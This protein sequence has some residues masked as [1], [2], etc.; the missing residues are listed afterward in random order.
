MLAREQYL[1]GLEHKP[2]EPVL[3]HNLGVSYAME[4]DYEHALNCF[5][6]AVSGHLGDSG[7]TT[8]LRLSCFASAGRRMR[9]NVPGN[10]QGLRGLQPHGRTL[11]CS[12]R[13]AHAIRC[14][15]RALELC[16]V[17]YKEAEDR[18]KRRCVWRRVIPMRNRSQRQRKV[19]KRAVW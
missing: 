12:R 19:E 18:L 3:Y 11:H 6:K 8:T 10:M 9:W 5:Q 13:R 7:S 14:Y 17:Y 15:T 4:G 1:A 16:P 2:D